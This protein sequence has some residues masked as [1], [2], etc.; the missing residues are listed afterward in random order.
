MGL[1]ATDISR[2]APRFE[3]VINGSQLMADMSRVIISLE[4]EQ[5]LNKLN[6]F[7][8]QVQDEYRPAGAPDQGSSKPF[9]WLGHPLF[10][11]GNDVSISAGYGKLVKMVEGKIQNIGAAFAQGLAPTL[12]VEGADKAFVFLTT[13]SDVATFRNKTDSDIVR[14]IADRAQ[15]DASVDRTSETFPVKIKQGGRSYFQFLDD[16]AR[17]NGFE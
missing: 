15:M 10:K 14:E 6:S 11:F 17:G 4:I 16:L 13:P 12:T 8:F 5:Q 7:K 1:S 9:R 3:L 2:Y